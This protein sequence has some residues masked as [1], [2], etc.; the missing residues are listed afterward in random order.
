VRKTTLEANKKCRLASEAKCASVFGDSAPDTLRSIFS[1]KGN[2][3]PADRAMAFRFSGVTSAGSATTSVKLTGY[4]IYRTEKRSADEPAL[5]NRFA[6]WSRARLDL[7]RIASADRL[8]FLSAIRRATF[9]VGAVNVAY[10]EPPLPRNVRSSALAFS[11][12]RLPVSWTSQSSRL[13]DGMC[14]WF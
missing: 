13:A 2:L 5:L 9:V 8:A 14:Q 4:G 12:M 6:R 7:L 3:N 11:V 10:T 1:A